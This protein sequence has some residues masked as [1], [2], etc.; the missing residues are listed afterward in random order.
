MKIGFSFSRCV[1]DIFE[2]KVDIDDVIVIIA[3]TDFDPLNN[4]Q[5]KNIWKGY[6]T[7]GEWRGLEDHEDD[8]RELARKLYSDGK[9]HQPRRFGAWPIGPVRHHWYDL[10]ATDEI[11]KENPAVKHA[12]EQY[13]IVIGLSQ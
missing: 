6:T 10:I 4:N 7:R 12:W 13:Q 3:R 9:L 8:V 5:W 2:N 1:R 11:N